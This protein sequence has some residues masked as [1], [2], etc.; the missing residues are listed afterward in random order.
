M[1]RHEHGGSTQAN[2]VENNEIRSL[3][4]WQWKGRRH[5][6]HVNK[7]AMNEWIQLGN[8]QWRLWT[9]VTHRCLHHSIKVAIW[10]CLF[11][12]VVAFI[13]CDPAVIGLRLNQSYMM[14]MRVKDGFVGRLMGDFLPHFFKLLFIPMKAF[15]GACCCVSTV[16]M[17]MCGSST[18]ESRQCQCLLLIKVLTLTKQAH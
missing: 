17:S 18:S 15:V 5:P 4:L 1:A 14:W 7:I 6:L 10:T 9:F 12:T 11:V 8:C 2:L 3:V 16:K 13:N